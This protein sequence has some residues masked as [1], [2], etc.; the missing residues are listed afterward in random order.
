MF[1]RQ[2]HTPAVA[3]LVPVLTH[4]FYAELLGAFSKNLAMS[5]LET[6]VGVP[7]WDTPEDAIESYNA[8]LSWKPQ[9]F[10]V[11]T[12]SDSAVMPYLAP[13]KMR[14]VANSTVVLTVNRNPWPECPAVFPDMTET[15]RL[16]VKHLAELGHRRIGMLSYGP[17]STSSSVK[18]SELSKQLQ[19]CDL[20]LRS[21]D[22]WVAPSPAQRGNLSDSDVVRIW[23]ELGKRFAQ[24]KDRPTAMVARTEP[25][26]NWFMTG[27][28]A[29]GGK[30]PEDLSI[31]TFNN[32][33]VAGMTPIPLTAV[34]TPVSVLAKAGTEL[35]REAVA[36]RQKGKKC[37]KHIK[38]APEL[39][40]RKTTCQA[41]DR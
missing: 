21:K 40:V 39:K 10:I 33:R 3:V 4:P 35:M 34:G 19:N 12:Y 22:V 16:I 15:A 6:M 20:G 31:I 41:P 30:V 7:H 23:F 37:I 2:P 26:A 38:L 17:I 14:S 9:A 29:A 18:V 28:M 27:F 32:S 8:F 5:D 11:I 1:L 36:A 24:T 13:E 25:I